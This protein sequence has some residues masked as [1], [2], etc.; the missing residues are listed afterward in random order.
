MSDTADKRSVA[1]DALE[2]L[3]MI[4]TNNEKRD[5]IHLAVIAVTAGEPIS[6]GAHIV[7]DEGT[8]YNCEEGKG[9]GIADPFLTALVEPGQRFWLIIYPRQIRS[10]RHVWEHPAFPSSLLEEMEEDQAAD[11]AHAQVITLPEPTEEQLAEALAM[12][13]HPV[14]LAKITIREVAAEFGVSYDWLMSET[15]QAQE[16]PNHYAYHPEDSGRFEGESLPQRFWDAYATVRG[17]ERTKVNDGGFFTCA[18]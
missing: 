13:G 16:D 8:A 14:E 9:Q 2:T 11:A 7:Y 6:P 5:A 12:M 3:G 10:L 18:C 15:D 4:H 17:V 1:T